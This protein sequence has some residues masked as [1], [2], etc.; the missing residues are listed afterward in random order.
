MESGTE[1]TKHLQG[2]FSFLSPSRLTAA[3]R[4]LP[5]A[6]LEKT[7]YIQASIAYCTKKETRV[8]KSQPMIYET[9]LCQTVVALQITLEI[10]KLVRAGLSIAQVME[11]L[12]LISARGLK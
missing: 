6:H 4:E 12:P 5:R 2:V 9:N 7:K 10:E 8:P 11:S 3:S 1:G